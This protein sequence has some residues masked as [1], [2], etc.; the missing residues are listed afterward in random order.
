MEIDFKNNKVGLSNY[1]YLILNYLNNYIKKNYNFIKYIVN[2][3][4]S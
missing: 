2:Y 3:K 4:I 1:K